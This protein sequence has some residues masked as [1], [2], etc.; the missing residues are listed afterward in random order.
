MTAPIIDYYKKKGLV[1]TV[2]ASKHPDEV[3]THIRKVINT[4][5]VQ[6]SSY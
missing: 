6:S 2:D 1:F 5:F 4:M 3:W